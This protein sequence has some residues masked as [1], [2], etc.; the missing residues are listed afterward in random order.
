MTFRAIDPASAKIYYALEADRPITT[1]N[2][3]DGSLVIFTDS[4]LED[5][6]D[7]VSNAWFNREQI[8]QTSGGKAAGLVVVDGLANNAVRVAAGATYSATVILGF[9]VL[10]E[11][12]GT[13]TFTPNTSGAT[14]VVVT[15]A[16][17]AEMDM[18]SHND[19][20][21]A[22]SSITA[23]TGMELLVYIP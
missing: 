5:S 2:I 6:F 23:G 17:I 18:I 14:P 8:A 13:L 20:P 22:C 11:G 7:A 19:W 15:A 9:R 3:P 12:S 10:L 4:G 16:E 21:I 1:L